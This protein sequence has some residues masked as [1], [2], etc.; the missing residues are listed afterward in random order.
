MSEVF[1]LQPI[2]SP[3]WAD[4]PHADIFTVIASD[5]LH[6]LHQGIFKDHFKKWCMVLMGKQD[7]NAHFHAM[8]V[9]SGLHHFKEGISKVKQWTGADHKQV[10][11][12]FL[13]ALIGTAPHPDVIKAGSSL[14]N[15]IY[16]AQYQSH[17][18]CMLVALQQALDGFHTAKDVFVKRGCHKHFNVPKIHSLQ[19][20]IEMIRSLG[21][22]DGLNT[23]TSE[24]LH[25]NFAKKAYTASN[26]RDYSIQMTRWLQCQEAVIWFSSFLTWLYD[27]ELRKFW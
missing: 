23:E 22:L 11:H 5:I 7:F 17:I 25:I 4:L 26:R 6:Q 21:S 19:H 18:D 15:F 9:F 8:P 2:F 24:W 12:I 27:K 16:L 3:F 13:T 10:Q 1:G 20:Y 14:L